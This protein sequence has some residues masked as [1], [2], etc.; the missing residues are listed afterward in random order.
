MQRAL[1]LSLILFAGCVS[2]SPTDDVTESLSPGQFAGL[3]TNDWNIYAPTATPIVGVVQDSGASFVDPI[4]KTTIKRIGVSA[5][6]TAQ[7]PSITSVMPFYA[8]QQAWSSDLGY[9]V[10][11]ANDG[12][13]QLFDGGRGMNGHTPYQLIRVLPQAAS[14]GFKGC[15]TD[16][17]IRW[18]TDPATPQKFFHVCFAKFYLYDAATN[19]DTLLVDWAARFPGRGYIYA[20]ADAEGNPS[21]IKDPASGMYNRYWAF[22]AKDSSG[23]TK[24]VMIYDRFTDKTAPATACSSNASCGVL[25]QVSGSSLNVCPGG[26][27]GIDWVGMSPTGKYVVLVYGNTTVAQ[28]SHPGCGVGVYST[29]LAWQRQVLPTDWHADVGLDAQKN[30]VVVGMYEPNTAYTPTSVAAE[31]SS[32]RLS[33]GYRTRMQLWGNDSAGHVQSMYGGQANVGFHVSM[34]ATVDPTYGI[35]GY[36]LISWYNGSTSSTLA[37]YGATLFGS[38]EQDVLYVPGDGTV[39]QAKIWRINQNR[40]FRVG[41][42][43]EPHCVPSPDF[44]KTLCGTNWANVSKELPVYPLVTEL[45]AGSTPPPPSDMATSHPPDM[46]TSHPPDMAT[47]HSPDLATSPPPGFTLAVNNPSPAP[48]GTIAAAYTAPSGESSSDMVGIFAA[49]ASNWTWQVAYSTQG[50]TSGSMQLVAPTTPGKYEVRYVI[51]TTYTAKAIVP[52]CV[53]GGC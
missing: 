7:N 21:S 23:A 50:A 14:T 2:S 17:E 25:S 16:N 29:S 30:E 51:K 40:S 36:A 33:D 47:S 52:L 26:S 49:G 1:A 11:W 19:T 28:T 10:T 6:T 45:A 43:D 3:K 37:Q 53:G 8:K 20:N 46:A 48:G 18:S 31:L 38:G 35:P 39:A 13:I 32:V 15:G 5:A 41:Y 42:N 24:D 22:D 27:S 44:T 9:L 4:F 34:R 12:S